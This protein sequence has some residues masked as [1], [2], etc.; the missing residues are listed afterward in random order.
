MQNMQSSPVGSQDVFNVEAAIPSATSAVIATSG[1]ITTA[2]VSQARVAPAGA[3]TGIIMQPGTIP[4]Q[5]V[6][7][8]NESAA[9]NT[10]TFNTAPATANVADAATETAIA[11]LTG[12]YFEWDAVTLL[13]Y[14][15]A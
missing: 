10:V 13:W 2:G 3:V 4:G 8:L 7:V 5:R 9:A 15:T 14:R 11:G 6:F 12:R 1:T